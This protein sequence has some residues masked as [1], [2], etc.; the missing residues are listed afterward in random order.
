MRRFS[1][2]LSSSNEVKNFINYSEKYDE[3]TNNLQIAFFIFTFQRANNSIN[4]R[5]HRPLPA[6]FLP[7][8]STHGQSKN[9]TAKINNQ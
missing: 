8:L 1:S 6:Q 2:T 3:I 9:I 5:H 7:N 4:I